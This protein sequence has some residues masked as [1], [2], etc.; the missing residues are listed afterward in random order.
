MI[1]LENMLDA[2]GNA[3]K[4]LEN[5]TAFEKVGGK[6]GKWKITITMRWV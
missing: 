3:M 1:K 2:P 6:E 4:N 5:V